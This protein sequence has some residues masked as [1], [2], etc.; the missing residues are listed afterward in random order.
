M[1]FVD[2]FVERGACYEHNMQV[3][4]K[5]IGNLAKANHSSAREPFSGQIRYIPIMESLRD[6]SKGSKQNK[7]SPL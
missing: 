2:W 6:T 5:H 4:D 3:L 7:D 1:R